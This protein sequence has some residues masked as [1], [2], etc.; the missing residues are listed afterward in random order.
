MIMGRKAFSELLQPGVIG[1]L[2]VKNRIV[3]TAAQWGDIAGMQSFRLHE[4]LARG[5]VGLIMLP[6]E[7]VTPAS[8]DSTQGVNPGRER[9]P[10]YDKIARVV[11]DY[12]AHIFLEMTHRGAW[13]VGPPGV[14][15][16][17]PIS[18][19]SLSEKELPPKSYDRFAADAHELTVAQIKEIVNEFACLCED[20]KEAGFDG[21]ELNASR[22]HLLNSFLSRFW[23]RREDEYGC[24]SIEN[25]TR[26]VAEIIREVK[27][28][29]GRDF[30]VCIQMNAIE[31]M[32]DGG[33]TVEESRGIAREL[34][35]AGADALEV[36]AYGYGE[37]YNRLHIPE[38]ICYPE[39]P[40]P[41][42]DELDNRH[43]GEGM[44]IPLVGMIKKAVSIP[45]IVVGKISPSMGEK[46]LRNGGAD[47]IGMCRGLVA[48]PD[49]PE[50]LAAGRP[51]EIA[52]CTTCMECFRIFDP[53][54]AIRCRINANV[55]S[56]E[57]YETGRA[58]ENKRV[59]VVGGG[60]AGMEAARVAAL[61]GHS[62][63][64]L[65]K[66]CSLGG[67]LR[68]AAFIKGTE[69]EDLP[70]IVRY[71]EIQLKKL[72]VEIKT[73]VQADASTIVRNHPEVVILATGSLPVLPEIVG[74]HKENVLDPSHLHHLSKIGMKL[75]GPN[76]LGRLSKVYMP[77][78]KRVVVIGGS[79]HGC[80]IAEFLAKRG[81]HV[82]I[83]DTAEELGVDMI[84]LN[85]DRLFAWF[86][87][88]GVVLIPGVEYESVTDDGLNIITRDGKR[89]TVIADTVIPAMPPKP[90]RELF[91]QLKKLKIQLH[92]VGDCKA[93]GL[94]IDAIRDGAAIAKNIR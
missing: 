50:K 76:G 17:L 30:P 92:T 91:S 42:A 78:G 44:T 4:A 29:L 81:R 59:L 67:S 70:G 19:S 31:Y 80:E 85:R 13:Q 43:K 24:G 40:R 39:P 66:E 61:R 35:K 90:D 46:T 89:Q 9:I 38:Q 63:T 5:G 79:M 69:T 28:R 25:R 34:E 48:D 53:Q 87:R 14:P 57:A 93:P 68:L 58:K 74:I 8:I 41:M 82:T 84:A 77:I 37:T 65:E 55:G 75:L 27:K 94:I 51:E 21:V 16:P 26:F 62:V 83:V 36:R 6:I 52:P 1:N 71:L 11:H 23:N 56:E 73:G 12:G 10:G 20:A 86:S 64:L 33:L 18:A 54:H 72:G 15:G 47:F 7:V 45:V 60:P 49:L 32:I 88:K 2:K 22:C 3:K